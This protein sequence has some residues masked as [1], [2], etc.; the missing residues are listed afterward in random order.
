[1]NPGVGVGPGPLQLVWVDLRGGDG[2][3]CSDGQLAG[4]RRW[5]R[6]AVGR[7]GRDG[8][9]GAGRMRS[10]LR[11]RSRGC[12]A[13]GVG[14]E[15][16]RG[17]GAS[18]DRGRVGGCRGLPRSRSSTGWCG[19]GWCRSGQPRPGG[20]RPSRRLHGS[21]RLSTGLGGGRREPATGRCGYLC[22]GEGPELHSPIMAG[23][24][25][26]GQTGSRPLRRRTQCSARTRRCSM[27]RVS[28]R[29]PLLQVALPVQAPI[30]RPL[31]FTAQGRLALRGGKERPQNGGGGAAG[32]REPRR[33]L[34]SSPDGSISIGQR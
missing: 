29:Q 10:A 34:P 16:R 20:R 8:R 31:A 27:R 33:P 28:I 23:T 18:G 2:Q 30:F 17:G 6:A 15:V 13:V 22:V 9:R 5:R 14:F 12:T 19:C 11:R 4:V 24:S 32:V 1:M 7:F 26:R 25:Q 21:M 3:C